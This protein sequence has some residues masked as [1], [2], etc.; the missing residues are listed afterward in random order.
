M[1]PP[2]R[3]REAPSGAPHSF[4]APLCSAHYTLLGIFAS[5]INVEEQFTLTI[6]NGS[7]FFLEVGAGRITE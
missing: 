3:I 6:S 2:T 1:P 5:L 4:N 7:A